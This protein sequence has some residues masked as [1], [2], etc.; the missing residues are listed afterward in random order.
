MNLDSVY[1]LYEKTTVIF[2]LKAF[3][4]TYRKHKYAYIT[5]YETNHTV[6]LPIDR[7]LIVIDFDNIFRCTHN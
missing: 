2:K 3:F 5:K 6:W 7:F 4:G 1:W